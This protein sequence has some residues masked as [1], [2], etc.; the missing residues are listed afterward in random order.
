MEILKSSIKKSSN[1]SESNPLLKSIDASV[2]S[3]FFFN[4]EHNVLLANDIS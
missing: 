3:K 2:K 4:A 1:S